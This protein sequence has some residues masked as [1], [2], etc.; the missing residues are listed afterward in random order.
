MAINQVRGLHNLLDLATV[1]EYDWIRSDIFNLV[2]GNI[3][4]LDGYILDGYSAVSQ[5]VV[6]GYG[7]SS[8]AIL[9]W[10]ASVL[11]FHNASVI[12][13]ANGTGSGAHMK[14]DGYNTPSGTL[15]VSN[16][17]GAGG[18]NNITA[19]Q[20]Y[21]NAFKATF[22]AHLGNTG[23]G[24]AGSVHYHITADTVNTISTANASSEATLVSLANAI[25]AAVQAHVISAF[26]SQ[27]IQIVSP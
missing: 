3:F 15:P 18:A 22:N 7:N 8:A 5:A 2:A 27:A 23:A 14:A 16:A 6:D 26:T 24:G 10:A 4:H 1:L 17:S 12:D 19:G 21:A 13:F 11:P 9:I 20:T 25:L